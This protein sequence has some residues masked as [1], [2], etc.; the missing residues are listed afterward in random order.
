MWKFDRSGDKPGIIAGIYGSPKSARGFLSIY[1]GSVYI[2]TDRGFSLTSSS[3]TGERRGSQDNV[4]ACRRS[5]SPP[6]CNSR[7]KSSGGIKR[8]L[9]CYRPRKYK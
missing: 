6:R 1:Q 3:T 8:L 2:T 4:A 5:P 7:L 9:P